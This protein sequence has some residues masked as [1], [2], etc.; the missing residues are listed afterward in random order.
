[1]SR[2]L[3]AILLI[4]PSV[5]SRS[6]HADALRRDGLG[7]VAVAD[8]NAAVAALATLTPQLII[9]SFDPRTRDECLAFCERLQVEARTRSVP[10]L[11]TSDAIGGDDM[12]R[13]TNTNALVLSLG[14]PLDET[15]LT[16]AVRGVL[17]VEDD[18]LLRGSSAPQDHQMPRSA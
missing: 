17:A 16:S 9:A 18:P 6:L 14:S 10:I 11:L 2:D 5:D 8:C 13:A 4:D 15:K 12:R 3:K 7:V 1:M